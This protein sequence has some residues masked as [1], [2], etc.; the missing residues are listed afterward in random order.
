MKTVILIVI[1]SVTMGIL[2]NLKN[3]VDVV[4]KVLDTENVLERPDESVI[5]SATSIYDIKLKTIDGKPASLAKYK[6]K[7]IIILNVASE[8]GYTPQYGDWEKFYEKNKS[9]FVILGFPAN[10]FGGQEPGSNAEIATFCTK[11]YGVTFP[12]FEKISVKGKDKAPL[13]QW[14]TTKSQNGWNEKEPT[15]NFCKYLVNENGELKNFFSSDIKPNSPE[16]L[17]AIK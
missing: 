5:N 8:C 13:Y 16:F 7:K 11:N 15:W 4:K 10:N 9:K 6:G 17:A 14:L 1:I 2:G 3:V 12:I